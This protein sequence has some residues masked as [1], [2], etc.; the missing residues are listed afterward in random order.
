MAERFTRTYT[1][2]EGLYTPGAPVL[3][4]AGALLKDNQ[5]GQM[6]AQL[7]IKNISAKEIKATAVKLIAFDTA[8]RKL[9]AGAEQQYLDLKVARDNYFGETVP[10]VIADNSARS[11]EV[12]V[13]EVVFAD[14]TIWSGTDTPWQKQIT[15]TPLSTT[16]TDPEL[17]TKYAINLE[18]EIG[19]LKC[20]LQ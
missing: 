18:K 11:Y 7:K 10:I 6:L 20:L 16:L 12:A 9:E 14:N 19:L 13:T 17:I 3:I 15:L 4:A 5:T 1:L 8:E 2:P